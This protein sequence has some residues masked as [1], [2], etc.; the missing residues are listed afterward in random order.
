MT[1]VRQAVPISEISAVAWKNGG[2]T[3]R[4]LAVEPEN[5][6]Y[7]DFLWRVSIADVT[8]SGRF[9]CFPNMDRTIILLDGEGM[10]LA[11]G[12][13][14][15]FALTTPFIPYTFRGETNIDG[16]L[17]AGPSR[18][19]NVMTLRGLASA[20]VDCLRAETWLPDQIDD[21]VLYCAHGSFQISANDGFA[22]AIAAGSVLRLSDLT[23]G[24]RLVPE[25]AGSVLISVCIALTGHNRK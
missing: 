24:G 12:D 23:P 10:V 5:A 6:G 20:T 7:D 9:S 8:A 14:S 21:A 1:V 11:G 18:D 2:G 16:T 19:F 3:T 15:E 4:T 22:T 25:Q 13:G 17:V